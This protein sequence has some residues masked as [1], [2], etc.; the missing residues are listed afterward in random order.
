MPPLSWRDI[1]DVR[2]PLAKSITRQVLNGLN[3]L[4]RRRVLHNG[5]QRLMIRSNSCVD[6]HPQNFLLTLNTG[7]ITVHAVQHMERASGGMTG[8]GCPFSEYSNETGQ[9]VKVYCSR[10][11]SICAD[12]EALDIHRLLV[13]IADFEK[14]EE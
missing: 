5:E 1:S 8:T 10:P 6:L 11:L 13:K 14:G 2:I 9:K 4:H 7:P 3:L 12:G